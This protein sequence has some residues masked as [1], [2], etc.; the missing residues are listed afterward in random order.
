M[1][2]T[3]SPNTRLSVADEI[4]RHDDLLSLPQALTEILKEIEKPNFNFDSLAK[5]ILKDPALTSRILKVANSSFYHRRTEITTVHQAVQILGVTTV[6]CLALSTSVFDAGRLDATTGVNS[7]QLFAYVLS[8]GAASEKIAQLVAFKDI[9]EVFIAGLLHEIGTLYFVHHHPQQYR[10][11]RHTYE[12]LHDLLKAEK[13]VFGLDHCEA[14]YLLAKRWRLPHSICEAIS[15]HHSFGEVKPGPSVSNIL[16]L[17]CLLNE[18]MA[19]TRFIELEDRLCRINQLASAMNLSKEKI[20]SI[21]SSLLSWTVTTANYLNIDIGSIEEILTRANSELWRT[22]LMLENLFKQRQELSQKLLAEEHARGAIESK[23]IAIATLSHYVNNATMAVYGRSQL[24]RQVMT[25]GDAQKLQKLLPAS[26][27]VIDR[28]IKKIV[29]VLAEIKE[30]SP[31]DEVSFYNMSQA[32][33]IDDRIERRLTAM[34][35]ESGL[36]LPDVEQISG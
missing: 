36:V 5:I 4:Q 30:I 7:K 22:Y 10:Q 28:S 35:H 9:E 33:K 11:V 19:A 6:K 2:T 20:D 34:E 23:N 29:A 21:S 31:I 27:D 12:E 26:L 14:G 24:L 17:A 16:R 1:A 15:D 25:G 3:I 32:M 13:V 18:D 8:V